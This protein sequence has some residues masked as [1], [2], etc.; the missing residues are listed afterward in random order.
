MLASLAYPL[1]QSFE[2]KIALWKKWKY[3]FP[4]MLITAGFFLIWDEFFTRIGV[5]SFSEK[6]TIGFNIGSLPFEE[7]LFFLIVPYCCFFVYFVAN[8][9]IKK[10]ILRLYHPVISALFIVILIA[11][12]SFNFNRWYT[13]FTCSSSAILIFYLAFYKRVNYLGRFYIGY[14]ISLI[15]FLI[16]NGVLTSKPVVIY[17]DS[18]NS[19]YRI[20]IEGF[21]NIPVE[22]LAYCLL[23]L[24]MNVSLYE[25]FASQNKRDIEQR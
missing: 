16:V 23:L 20:F 5:W 21:S 7:W 17:N 8:Y 18:E 1:A 19:G 6:Y 15:P 10:D 4:A 11:S 22:D 2:K 3:M 14:A 24:L 9:F 25:S 12:A 13:A